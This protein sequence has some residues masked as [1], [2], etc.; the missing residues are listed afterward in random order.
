[1]KITVYVAIGVEL[2]T[3]PNQY[4][5]TIIFPLFGEGVDSCNSW[6][7]YISKTI[8]EIENRE[9]FVDVKF[10]DLQM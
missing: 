8:K 4:N 7:Q 3:S 1:M 2:R 5:R 6:N 9:H 10:E